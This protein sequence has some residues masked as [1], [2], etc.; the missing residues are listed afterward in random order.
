MRMEFRE[1]RSTSVI[2]NLLVFPARD[3]LQD[4]ILTENENR[5]VFTRL[6]WCYLIL[7]FEIDNVRAQSTLKFVFLCYALFLSTYI[8]F[9]SVLVPNLLK[10]FLTCKLLNLK[11]CEGGSSTVV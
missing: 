5:D 3:A 11:R 10:D 6:L 2:K 1:N 9:C 4:Y 8:R 7:F